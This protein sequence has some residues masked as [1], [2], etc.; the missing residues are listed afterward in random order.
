MI[1]FI[2]IT[3]A[4]CS[5]EV[6]SE[7]NV[8]GT[9]DE[10]RVVGSFTSKGTGYYPSSSAL[11]GGFKDRLGKP[12]KTLQQFLNGNAS[13]VSV[14]MDSTAFKYGTRLRI[15]E[16]EQK[17]GRSIVFRVVDT[18]GAFRGKG[19]S[20]IDVCVQNRAASLDRT[21]NGTLHIEVIDE[22]SGPPQVDDTVGNP[23]GDETDPGR[24]SSGDEGRSCANSGECNPGSVG[25][26]M[27]CQAGK[28]VAGCTA[29][30]MCPNVCDVAAKKCR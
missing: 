17:Y 27:M 10:I 18:G 20:R 23:R 30:W 9:S 21:I 15:R 13:Y 16:L 8:E 29:N 3:L 25:S 1:G 12:L 11:E 6:E 24:E 2:V 26:G 14:A 19:R 28:C 7:E 5:S 4:G 22:T